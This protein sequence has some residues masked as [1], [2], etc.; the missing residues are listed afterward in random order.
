MPQVTTNAA[1][2]FDEIRTKHKMKND[3]H[4]ARELDVS[5]A[6]VSSMRSQKIVFG[7]AMEKR[8]LSRNLMSSRRIKALLD[9]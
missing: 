8:I 4:L 1:A 2:V 9:S 7:A 6:M 3:A 5:P